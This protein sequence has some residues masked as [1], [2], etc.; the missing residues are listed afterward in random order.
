MKD[1]TIV[2]GYGTKGRS[3]VQTLISNGVTSATASW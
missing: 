1:H 3:A 2:V